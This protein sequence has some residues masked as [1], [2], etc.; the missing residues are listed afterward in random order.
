MQEASGPPLPQ[1]CP[2]PGHPLGFSGSPSNLLH[3]QVLPW[4]LH[5]ARTAWG[6]APAHAEGSRSEPTSS[7]SWAKVNLTFSWRTT[8]ASRSGNFCAVASRQRPTVLLIRR[9]LVQPWT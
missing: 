8:K 6:L 1:P 5:P 7:F 9:N 3:S 2:H 4:W